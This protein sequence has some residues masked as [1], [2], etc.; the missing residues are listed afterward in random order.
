MLF[1]SQ[2]SNT[3]D[4]W[5]ITTVPPSALASSTALTGPLAGLLQQVQRAAGGVKFGD[6]VAATVAFQTDTAQNATQMANAL[7]FLANMAQMQGG[8]NNQQLAALAKG[9]AVTTTGTTVKISLTLPEAQFQQLL[10][11]QQKKATAVPHAG[12]RN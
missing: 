8:Q 3:E 11:M 5:L 2:W 6:S 12:V 7:Q 1:R 10:Q 4:A 9:L